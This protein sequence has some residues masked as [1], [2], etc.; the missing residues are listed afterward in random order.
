[1]HADGR[2]VARKATC[3]FNAGAYADISPRLIKNGGYAA[4][5]LPNPQ[6]LGRLLRGLHQFVPAGR[7]SRLRRLAGRLGL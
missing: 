1:M 2:I 7:L 4:R 3:Y 5:A 6:C